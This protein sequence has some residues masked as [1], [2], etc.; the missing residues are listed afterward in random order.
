MKCFNYVFI[1]LLLCF[2]LGACTTMQPVT[3]NST[4]EE[5]GKQIQPGDQV[6]LTTTNGEQHEFVFAYIEDGYIFGEEESYKLE[7]IETLEVKKS[8]AI[9]ATSYVV[10]YVA[11]QEILTLLIGILIVPLLLPLVL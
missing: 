6:R 4:A 2:S 9:G 8:T 10:A 3:E 11:V 7:D 1:A 5:I